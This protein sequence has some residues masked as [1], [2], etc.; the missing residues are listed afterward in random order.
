MT[1]FWR[2][3]DSIFTIFPFWSPFIN[4]SKPPKCKQSN[5]MGSNFHYSRIWS[6]F[7]LVF[8]HKPLAAMFPIFLHFRL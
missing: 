3:R 5:K 7:F 6:P 4:F 8:N 1:V 2:K